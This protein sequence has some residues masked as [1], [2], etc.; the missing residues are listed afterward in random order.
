MVGSS[1]DHVQEQQHY[2]HFYGQLRIPMGNIHFPTLR[3]PKRFEKVHKILTNWSRLQIAY[4][5]QNSLES[6]R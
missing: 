6:V 4:K 5:D 3:N 1:A 2:E